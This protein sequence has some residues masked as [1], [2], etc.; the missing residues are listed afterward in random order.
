MEGGTGQDWHEM[1]RVREGGSRERSHTQATGRE[2]TCLAETVS[3]ALGFHE[4][5]LGA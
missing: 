4:N 2:G 3:P 5:H 1:L